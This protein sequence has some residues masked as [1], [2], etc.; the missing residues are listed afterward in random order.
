MKKTMTLLVGLGLIFQLFGQQNYT[1]IQKDIFYEGSQYFFENDYESALYVFNEL[2]AVDTGF[3][4]INFMMGVCLMK[5]RGRRDEAF[6][7]LLKAEKGDIGEA[8]FWLGRA[9]HL[10]MDFENALKHYKIYEQAPIKEISKEEIKRYIDISLKAKEMVAHPVDADIINI[11]P[12]INTKYPEYVPLVSADKN[13]MYFTSRR[14]DGTGKKVDEFDNY[15]EDIYYSQKNDGKWAPAVNVGPPLNTETHDATV[16]LSANGNHLIIYRTSKNLLGGNLYITEHTNTGWST[17]IKLT[18]NVN[19]KFQEASAVISPNGLIM[20]ISSNR[21]GGLG[22]KDLYRVRK[23]PNGQWSLP[24][25]LGPSINTPY[26]EDAPFIHADGV[27]L[28]YSSN[29]PGTM[30]GYDIFKTTLNNNGFWSKPKN[31][32]YP[33]NTVKDDIYFVVSPDGMNGYYSSDKPEG[34]GNQDIYQINI[35]FDNGQRIIYHGKSIDKK[36]KS[37][38]KSS[39]YLYDPESNEIMGEYLSNTRNGKFILILKPGK[40]YQML[41]QAN[42][43]EDFSK[44]IRIDALTDEKLTEID[45]IIELKTTIQK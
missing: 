33:I 39:I 25:N 29:G 9:Y 11:G 40:S 36:S 37:P 34:Y 42:G 13:E 24:E 28:Y 3:S 15:F 20:Y 19:S 5:I 21:P 8:D 35:N 10:R 1:H 16:S 27:S 14:P 30:G 31:M 43:Y 6:P 12:G 4:E 38:I 22:G 23:L 18:E 44:F 45:N 17:P 41:V 32:G 7:Y 2:Y 26:D